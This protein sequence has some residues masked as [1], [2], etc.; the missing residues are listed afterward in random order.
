M[1]AAEMYEADKSFQEYVDRCS[2]TY[3]VPVSEVL[4]Y[5]IVQEVAEYYRK[6]RKP[7]PVTSRTEVMTCG[8]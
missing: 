5:R 7:Q 4:T 3:H 6:D 2:S 8:C 1:T